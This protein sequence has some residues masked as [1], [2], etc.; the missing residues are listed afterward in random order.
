MASVPPATVREGYERRQGRVRGRATGCWQLG[1]G[2]MT[3]LGLFL[4]GCWWAEPR[5]E[6]AASRAPH[7][8]VLLAAALPPWF[9]TA[10]LGICSSYFLEYGFVYFQRRTN[11]KLTRRLW[12][13]RSFVKRC[14]GH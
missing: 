4:E 13:G 9:Q 11:I 2:D 5:Q 12:V 14:F 3:A 8:C 1:D 6:I 7:C 10:A